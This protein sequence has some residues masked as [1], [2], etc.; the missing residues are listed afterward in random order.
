MPLYMDERM[1]AYL[2]AAADRINEFEALQLQSEAEPIWI[3][4][5]RCHR[6][7][8]L[9]CFYSGIGRCDDCMRVQEEG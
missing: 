7:V 2:D 1:A 9:D 3:T 5:P 8:P 4:C 6:E